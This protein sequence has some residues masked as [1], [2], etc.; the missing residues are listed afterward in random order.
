MSRFSKFKARLTVAFYSPVLLLLLSSCATVPSSQKYVSSVSDLK[1]SSQMDESFQA[2]WERRT[3]YFGQERLGGKPL[4]LGLPFM[5]SGKPG[6][7]G[8]FPLQITA[9][10]MDSLLIEAGLKHYAS[11]VKMNPEEEVEF[12]SSYYSRYSPSNHLLIWCELQTNWA[13]LHLDLKRWTIFIEDDAGNQYEPAQI[14]EESQP[15]RRIAMDS[16][17]EF[18]LGIQNKTWKVNRK[19][20]MLCFP[21]RDFY[22]KPIL[23]DM[24]KSLK[25]IF[26]LINDSQT[27][28]EGIWM[29]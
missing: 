28:A 24:T 16:M 9:T 20:L 10:L 5:M 18:Q 11:L 15:D 4:H 2:L 21:K 7:D 13:E 22:Q 1:S 12:R 14:L 26:Q 6:G 25:L 27:R 8:E 3:V 17:S 29:F 19:I 23:S